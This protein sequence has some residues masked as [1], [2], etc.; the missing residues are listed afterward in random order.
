M[1]HADHTS[2]Q[3]IAHL[4]IASLFVIV[5]I[6]NLLNWGNTTRR[7]AELN[8]PVP[9][10]SFGLALILQ[11]SGAFM[12]AADYFASIGA[13]IFIGFTIVVSAFYHRFWEYEE[14]RARQ[15]H[16]QFVCNNLAVI[17][18]LMLIV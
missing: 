6:R 1:F 16:F 13:L 9:G 11:F 17:G 18:G 10:F 7:M 14:P 4:L 5:G 15:V 8:V 12:V 2:L 3:I